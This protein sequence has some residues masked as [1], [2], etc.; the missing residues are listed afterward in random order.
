MWLKGLG[1]LKNPVTSG[2]EPMTFKFLAVPQTNWRENYTLDPDCDLIINS[3][4]SD[5]D[6]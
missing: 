4:K 5:S 2:I 6:F 3:W 1:Q